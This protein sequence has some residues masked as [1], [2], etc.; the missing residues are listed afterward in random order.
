[1]KKQK[2]KIILSILISIF[3][4][5][6]LIAQTR[7]FFSTDNGLSNSL[8]NQI[9]QDKEGYIWIATEYGLN[10]F[11]GINFTTYKQIE[12]DPTSI[13]HNYIRTI[14]ESSTG[15]FYIGTM[16][17]LMKYDSATDSFLDIELIKENNLVYPHISSITE[18]QN[19]DIWL[20]TSGQGIFYSKKGNNKFKFQSDLTFSLNS[21]YLNF[22]FEDSQSRIWIGSESDGLNL[23]DPKTKEIKSF[24]APHTINSNNIS[25]ISE[26][27]QGNIY[28][29]T[30]TKGL[31]KFDP[32]EQKF[33][34]IKHHSNVQLFIKSLQIDDKDK[35]YIGT[36]G[37][38][39]MV[40]NK[41]E[42]IIEDYKLNSVPFDL[43]KGKV[44]SIL[45]DKDKNIWLGFF[46]KGLFFIPVSGNKFGY[47]GYKSIDNNIIGSSSVTAIYKDKEGITWVGT[48][49]DGIYGILDKKKET[50]HFKKT[51]DPNSPPNIIHSIL[52]DSEGNLWIGSYT[53]GLAKMNKKTGECQYIQYF[54]DKKVYF[55]TENNTGELLVGTFGSGV[56]ILNKKGNIIEH[57]E[58][59]KR[60][61]DILS[62]DELFNDWINTI[63]CDKEGL[64]W[65]GHFKGLS[66]FNPLKKTFLTFFEKN[67]I[68][69]GTVVQ[70]LLED[71]RG[72]IWIGTTSGLYYFNKK[73]QEI[74]HFTT[75]NGLV[76]NVICGICEDK[77]GNLWISTYHGMSKFKIKEKHFVNYFATDGLQ[78]NEFTKGAVYQDNQ[79][80]VYFGG[81]NG[82]T[83]FFPHEIIE[84]KKELHVTLT[85]FYIYNRAIK[86]GDKSN[87]H[88][89][90]SSSSVSETE[91]FTLNHND[92]TFSFEFSTF[93]FSNPERISYEYKIE[94]IDTEWLSTP[95]GTNRITYNNLPPGK[96]KLKVRA[97][98]NSN[99][100]PIKTYYIKIIPPWYKSTWAYIAYCIFFLFI[101]YGIIN[102][103]IS[104]IHYRQELIKK[105]HEKEISEAKLQ[106]FINISHEIRTPMTLIINPL[107]KLIKENK[108]Q[109]KQKTYL[110]IYRNAQ[111]ILRLINQLMDIRKLDKGQ[112]KLKCRETNIVGFIED[113]MLTFEYEAKR[114]NIDFS[115][116]HK[117]ESLMVW[118]D[119]NNLDKVLMN[120]FSN[121]FKYTPKNGEIRISLTTG[122]NTQIGEY[123]EISVI[124]SGIGID[125]NQI[126]NIFERF[127][128]IKNDKTNSNFGTG[129]GLHLAR[130]LVE[131]HSGILFA[132]NRE[133]A[134][135]SRFIIR[136][137]LGNKHLK[138]DEFETPQQE[139]H[140]EIL[141]KRTNKLE[142]AKILNREDTISN[143]EKKAKTKYRILIVEDEEEIRQYI[144][145]EISEDY[146][147]KEAKNGKEALEILLKEKPDLVI[148]D[149]MMPEMDGI[150]LCKKIKQNININHIPIILLTAKVQVEN[151]IEGLEIGAD[152]YLTK[153]FN[154]EI[155]KQTIHNLIANRQR[156]KSSFSGSQHQDDKIKKIELKSADEIFIEKVMKVIND[157]LSNPDLNVEM[158][159]GNVGMSRVHMH[160]KLKELT[161]Q[162]ARDFIRGIRLKQAAVLL[163]SDKK[164]YVS[165]VA[166]ATGFNNLSH[167]SNSFKEFYG[168]SPTEYINNHNQKEE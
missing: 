142:V 99:Y 73:T 108:D 86:K 80:K 119:L 96:Y 52:E 8:I 95:N 56:Y 131:M 137:P 164:L 110:M 92:N 40:Y 160:R 101:I 167:F 62:V 43:T 57:F 53:N 2:L 76:N 54:A 98:E 21:I 97:Y 66:C 12:G 154:S 49:N 140:P 156:L 41:E 50:Y 115:F 139:I 163:T 88:E 28:V 51:T 134:Q 130:L 143:T 27:T 36:D 42:N 19:G 112:M 162:S 153:P 84:Q 158:L 113:L 64:I 10:K 123:F 29:G 124:D 3:F 116:E 68:L 93:E 60:E 85:N 75:D 147:V 70:V 135:G 69:P 39:L 32:E 48:D 168:M 7:T 4:C 166:Y 16:E 23:Y 165:E 102:Y 152:A 20:T 146:R 129:I 89:I 13:R 78:G 77:E 55:I 38:G 127:Y 90:L 104:R 15:D 30:L 18:T 35:L 5:I 71:K 26:D 103:I 91:Y 24:Q 151:K 17:G 107:E 82:V 58:S 120:I 144:K 114:K 33:H 122:E 161:N 79:G 61:M 25:V 1:M 31:S 81:I 65:I 83:C 148:S 121:A 74:K 72:N 133:D 118:I 34:P 111:R 117:L 44:H 128:Q 106:F 14:F 109:K 149:I 37:Q 138:P 94:D 105:E 145:D 63:M 125:E 45:F 11:D 136:L 150:D 132:E 9:Y 100:S 141:Q 67:N 46:Q 87:K 6:S 59:S 157:N 155:L 159:A 126:E 47:F 22:I